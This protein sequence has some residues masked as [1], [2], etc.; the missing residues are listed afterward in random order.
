MGSKTARDNGRSQ[1]IR[2][3]KREHIATLVAAGMA[4]NPAIVSA[5]APEIL[6]VWLHIW[7]A[8]RDVEVPPVPWRKVAFLTSIGALLVG[9]A[10]LVMIPRING[11]QHPR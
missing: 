4:S 3:T 8:P 5:S 11:G 1:A 9:I 2:L 6:G 10:L 7:T